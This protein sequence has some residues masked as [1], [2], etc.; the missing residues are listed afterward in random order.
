[1]NTS[2]ISLQNASEYITLLSN[3]MFL[4]AVKSALSKSQ[5]EK[6]ST[7]LS[8]LE[9][10]SSLLP[11][12]NSDSSNSSLSSLNLSSILGSSALT[13]STSESDTSKY[14]DQSLD[15]VVSDLIANADL[16]ESLINWDFVLPDED[17]SSLFERLRQIIGKL[18]EE[19]GKIREEVKSK[20]VKSELK[21]RPSSSSKSGFD[22]ALSLVA[23]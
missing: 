13:S 6:S 22:E 12:E 3:P 11:V 18:D 5:D 15:Q 4:N 19:M 9:K 8:N 10:L 2:S 7:L 1:M 21:L 17:I 16:L 14:M 20:E 23:Q